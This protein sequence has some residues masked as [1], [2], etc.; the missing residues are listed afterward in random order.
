MA[1]LNV[2]TTT[3]D[4]A[5][6]GSPPADIG[7]LPLTERILA[8]LP[9]VR[10]AWVA[11][12]AL[13]GL[14]RLGVL[15]AIL[16]STGAS[17]ETQTSAGSA[18]GQ[19]IYVYV[20]LITL[21]GTRTLVRRVQ[22][23]DPD[24]ASIA[25]SRPADSWFGRMTST[26]GP[27]V[28]TAIAVAAS[29][30]STLQ[31]FGALVAAVDVVLLGVLLLPVMTFIWAYLTLLVG[32]DRL[33]RAELRLDDASQDRAL[34]LG[35]VGAVAMT[36]FWVLVLAVA[37][38]LVFAGS[39][40]PTLGASVMTL[41]TVVGLFALSM[42]RLH[43][44]MRDE[45][46]RRAAQSRA[47]VAEAYAPFRATPDLETLQAAKP[48]LDAAQGLADRTEKLLEWPI[49]ERMVAWITVVVTGVA[50]SLVVRFVLQAVGA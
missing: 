2:T 8:A 27:V 1:G 45:K 33:G 19:A 34:G 16:S 40:L 25:P 5:G 15:I 4:R 26:G 10:S 14:L 41:G 39:D 23:L 11:A 31:E 9:G 38:L 17:I 20:V 43:G 18:F 6:S 37:P 47:L 30:P 29:V 12:W 7:P 3:A 24:L 44:Q 22:E 46:A 42:V 36:G 21:T 28:L 35:G 49:D 48:A 50:T 13:V 32:L